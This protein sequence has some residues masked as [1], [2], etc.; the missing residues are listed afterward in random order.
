MPRMRN[1]GTDTSKR[2]SAIHRDNVIV[3]PKQ[4]AQSNTHH[5]AR[6]GTLTI[7]PARPNLEGGATMANGGPSNILEMPRA[8]A[9]GD[10]FNELESAMSAAAGMFG[11]V[12]DMVRE[13]RL[14]CHGDA[15]A[16]DRY[17]G[18]SPKMMSELQRVVK[19]TRPA[20]S[21]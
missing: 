8:S 4:G 10:R 21:I 11:M 18:D 7:M 1:K 13:L 15:T 3:M 9:V 16:A 5:P 20:P 14:V 2:G 19:R 17:V 12:V 6:R